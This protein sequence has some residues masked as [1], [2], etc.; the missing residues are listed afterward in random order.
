MTAQKQETRSTADR[1]LSETRIYD[2]P[3]ELVWKAWTEPE[4]L[5]NWWGPDG[6]TNTIHEMDV[7]PG[8][9]WNLV[10]HGPD[11]RDYDNR[12]IYV[13]VVKPERI[14]YD[15]T[16]HPLFRATVTFE[17]LAGKTRLTMRMVFESTES[18]DQTVKVFKAD[19]GLIQTLSRLAE[20]LVKIS[21]R[22]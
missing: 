19:E 12:M 15:H 2:A 10:M 4:H 6:F 22:S 9:A 18:R 1:E 5:A 16:S 13:E 17:D 8:G 21:A 11:G 14:V 20:Q 7:R 3:R